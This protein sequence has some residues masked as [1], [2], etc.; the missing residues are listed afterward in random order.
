MAQR[1]AIPADSLPLC[2]GITQLHDAIDAAEFEWLRQYWAQGRGHDALHAY[3]QGPMRALAQKWQ[4]MRRRAARA[5]A[6]LEAAA[7]ALRGDGGERRKAAP[8]LALLA[9]CRRRFG[10]RSRMRASWAKRTDVSQHRAWRVVAP[11]FRP[12]KILLNSG[13]AAGGQGAAEEA[14]AAGAA[15]AELSSRAAKAWSLLRGGKTRK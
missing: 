14:A 9:L 3:W 12:S 2:P 1:W 7:A 13:G 5:L 10:A 11:A 15:A 6:A 4:E 8:L